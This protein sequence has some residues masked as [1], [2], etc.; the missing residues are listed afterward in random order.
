MSGNKLVW[1]Y[2]EKLMLTC[3]EVAKLVS[4][5]FEHKL[6]LHKR[7]AMWIHYFMCKPC[8]YYHKHAY[9]IRKLTA[10]YRNEIEPGKAITGLGLASEARERIK[11]A[12]REDTI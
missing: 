12:L 3:K 11:L 5:S 7:I 10:T 6:P 9:Y 2:K 1:R 4:E 8:L